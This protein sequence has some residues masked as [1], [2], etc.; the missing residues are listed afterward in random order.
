MDDL[1]L[2][3]SLIGIAAFLHDIGKPYQRSGMKLPE[4]YSKDSFERQLILN[5]DSHLHALHTAN[6]FDHF[7]NEQSFVARLWKE[8][9]PEISMQM[10]SSGHHNPGNRFIEKLIT[11][12]DQI[13]SGLD[14]DDYKMRQNLKTFDYRKVQMVP[15]LRTVSLYKE[16]NF[17]YRYLLD[18]VNYNSIFPVK[19]SERKDIDAEKDYKKIIDYFESNFQKLDN[20]SL[21]NFIDGLISLYEDSFSFV[22]ASTMGEY[23]DI[24]LYDHSKTAAA[25]ATS[26]FKH[27]DRLPESN[28]KSFMVIR[29]EFFGIQK[30]IFSEG[31]DPS[32]NPAKILRGRS[33][34]VSLMT[35][36]AADM[37]L[38]ELSLPSF[39]LM[40]NAAGMFVILADNTEI[41][42]QK[43]KE[44]E[45]KIHYWLFKKFQGEVYF[46]IFTTEATQDDFTEKHF[47]TLWL[48]ILTEMDKIKFSK[49]NLL[50]REAVFLDYHKQFS[51][52]KPCSICGRERA[53]EDDIGDNCREVIE[54]GK[55]LVDENLRYLIIKRDDSGS[56]FGAYNYSFEESVTFQASSYYTKVLDIS[57]SG[58]FRGY[59]K[60]KLNTYVAKNGS[61]IKTFEEL[62]SSDDTGAEA[63]GVFK[64][65]VDNMAAIFAVGLE[66]KT[67]KGENP[68]LTFSRISQLSRMINNFFAYYLPYKLRTSL[69]YKDTY[70]VFA[71]GDDLFIIG[72]YDKIFDLATEISKDFRKY[73]GF[74][75]EVTI[76]G[77]ISIFK[78]NTP[79]AFMAEV[80][81]YNLSR[82]KTAING[83][84]GNLTILG[85][86]AKWDEFIKLYEEIQK[87]KEIMPAS[88]SF[89]YKLLEIIEMRSRLRNQEYKKD[90]IKNIMWMPRLQYIIARYLKEKEKREELAMYLLSNIENNEELFRAL[91]MLE[92]YKNRKNKKYR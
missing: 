70:T 14:R 31:S 79:I 80:V 46:G 65:D 91:S 45:E 15:L 40:I 58:N 50:N 24:S 71:G 59:G 68:K 7:L 32:A 4:K 9:F 56:I 49:F 52:G 1:L 63:I 78:P 34:Y 8:S 86:T 75:E 61:A 67:N 30:F 55:N 62:A 51:N 39:N 2:R 72:R 29:G 92:I 74:N 18:I 20:T 73:T 17:D 19:L 87:H 77:G 35:E 12:S 3:T 26:L 13:A 47:E 23:D 54:I 33:F 44:V 81:E 36:I 6:F 41:T 64:A 43:V 48:N 82:S 28:E 42:K 37:L 10:A 90:L 66:E 60:A 5:K 11:L 25:I 53:T 83:E 22:P 38:T 21:K 89:Q 88:S 27:G 76:S 69:N 85:A 16:K 57:L 84:K